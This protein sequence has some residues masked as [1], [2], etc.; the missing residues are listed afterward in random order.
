MEFHNFLDLH[1]KIA[2]LTGHKQTSEYDCKFFA[3][4]SYSS[5]TDD[6][7][8]ACKK[9]VHTWSV[10]KEWMLSC[11]I[12]AVQKLGLRMSCLKK[13]HITEK[14]L[15][16]Q[17]AWNARCDYTLLHRNAECLSQKKPEEDGKEETHVEAL[18]VRD[19]VLSTT[20]KVKVTT[21]N[22][23]STI[24]R[25][26]IDPNSSAWFVHE[27]LVQHLL[28]P[29]QNKECNNWRSCWASTST[30]GSVWFRVSGI[31]DDAEKVVVEAYML[32]KIT[33]DLLH[34][35]QVEIKWDHLTNPKLA[36]SDFR[37]LACI[38]C[39]LGLKCWRA[40]FVMARKLD[41]KARHQQ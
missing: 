29:R 20:C 13:G 27:Q 36:D 41:L 34:P 11:R 40:Y 21:A 16:H 26:L 31:E 10:F 15:H 1:L 6:T 25:T 30:G 12:S 35:I 5:S 24:A 2:S 38:I 3:K 32:R 9:C 4:Q 37:T 22:G 14:C 33:K 19:Q 18:S 39:C 8:L 7:C 17:C 28:L 23:S